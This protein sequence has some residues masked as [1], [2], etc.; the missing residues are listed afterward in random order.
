MRH[1]SIEWP[2]PQI[3]NFWT[4]TVTVRKVV[5]LAQAGFWD[6]RIFR[7][8]AFSGVSDYVTGTVYERGWTGARVI[9]S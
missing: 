6:F 3:E 9:A 2:F 8:H 5:I 7:M 4:Y 1:F